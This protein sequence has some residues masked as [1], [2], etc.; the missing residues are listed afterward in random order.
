MTGRRSA[1]AQIRRN[2]ASFV[3]WLAHGVALVVLTLFMAARGGFD[4]WYWIIG[5]ALAISNVVG[6]A[7]LNR[8][9]PQSGPRP[10]DEADVS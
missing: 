5:G 1:V 4:R 3:W 9:S 8:R 7:A 2:P 6:Q 10:L